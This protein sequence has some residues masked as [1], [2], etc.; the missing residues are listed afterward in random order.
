[1]ETKRVILARFV[2]LTLPQQTCYHGNRMSDFP[3]NSFFVDKFLG[4]QFW[5]LFASIFTFS[6]IF[7]VNTGHRAIKVHVNKV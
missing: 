2:D 3:N 4:N 6:T 1:M 5:Q 7:L